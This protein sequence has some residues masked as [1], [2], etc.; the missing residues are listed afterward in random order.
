MILNKSYLITLI[1]LLISCSSFA[2]VGKKQMPIMPIPSHIENTE[3]ANFSNKVLPK[4]MAEADSSRGVVAKIIDNSLS[5][6]WE[7]SDFKK[8]SVGQVAEKIENNI[9]AD[10][11]LSGNQNGKN[12]H[13]ISFRVLAAQALA[14]LE[15]KGWFKGAIK[16]DAKKAN[17]EAEVLE[18]LSNNKDLVITHTVTT[19]ENKS[20][21]SLR[22]NW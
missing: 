20:Q 4:T 3:V 8:T 7:N 9:K 17:A 15:Y 16:Y 19:S 18:N 12:E 6:W 21:L 14:K 11:N 13:K 2:K 10:I 22:W 5:Y 1:V